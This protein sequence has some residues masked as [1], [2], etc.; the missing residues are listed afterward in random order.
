MR[1]PRTA[2]LEPKVQCQIPLEQST[3]VDVCPNSASPHPTPRVLLLGHLP[4]RAGARSCF[5]SSDPAWAR[6]Q[7]GADLF[8]VSPNLGAK[9]DRVPPVTRMISFQFSTDQREGFFLLPFRNGSNLSAQ[10]QAFPSSQNFVM[11]PIFPLL[12]KSLLS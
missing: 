9:E 6:A 10:R 4:V 2:A 3:Q 7:A 8:H 11:Q 12:I 5:F 1:G